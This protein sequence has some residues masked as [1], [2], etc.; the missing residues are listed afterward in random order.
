MQVS[1]RLVTSMFFQAM[2][3]AFLVQFFRYISSVWQSYSLIN[4]H[5]SVENGTP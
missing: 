3:E 5:S 1:R 4:I 2:A